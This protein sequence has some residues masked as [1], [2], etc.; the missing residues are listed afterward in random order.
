MSDKVI[1]IDG[2][3]GSGK[4]TVAKL[5]AKKLNYDYLD[6]GAMYRAVTWF[7]LKKKIDVNDS[8]KL[9]EVA[10]RI[11][12]SFSK[13]KVFVN[14]EDVTGQI[15]KPEIDKNVSYV[16]RIKGVREAMVAL[17]RKIAEKGGIIVDGR[18]IGSRVLPDAD[19]KVYLTASLEERAA[20]RYQ[21]IK[22]ENV[23]LADV[24]KELKKRDMIDKNRKISPLIKAA[25]ANYLD[26]TNMSI[27]Q[28]IDKLTKLITGE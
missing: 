28:V 4:S 14:K 3:G 15:R 17:Q 20:R 23:T 10:S 1:A 6:T 9:S 5:L 2:P 26:T 27:E 13:N 16:A 21:D 22:K 24:K 7:A 8:H 19:I 12:I 11:N 18:D 25:D